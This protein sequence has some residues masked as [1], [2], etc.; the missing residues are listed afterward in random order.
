MR[1]SILGVTMNKENQND[2]IIDFFMTLGIDTKVENKVN[3]KKAE[4]I[5]LVYKIMDI[6]PKEHGAYEKINELNS[7]FEE[8]DTMVKHDYINFGRALEIMER[9]K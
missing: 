9:E 2:F 7:L 4:L 6:I 5:D 1:D 8:C 3:D